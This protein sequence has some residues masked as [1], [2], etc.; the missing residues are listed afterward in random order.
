MDVVVAA[1]VVIIVPNACVIFCTCCCAVVAV[2]AAVVVAAV[3]T[4]CNNNGLANIFRAGWRCGE[5]VVGGTGGDMA[6][7]TGSDGGLVVV[8]VAVAAVL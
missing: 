4:F 8:A 5:C 6:V 7:V 2:F 1:A 3:T